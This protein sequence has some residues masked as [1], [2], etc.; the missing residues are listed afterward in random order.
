MCRR[1][2]E[3]TPGRMEEPESKMY[4]GIEL[5]V[6]DREETTRNSKNPEI[7]RSDL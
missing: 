4:T 1:F 7:T 3:F 6:V 5:M 2:V